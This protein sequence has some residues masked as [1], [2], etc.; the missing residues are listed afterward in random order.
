MDVD[1]KIAV[2]RRT[3]KD[4]K[5]VAVAFSGGV[6]SALLAVVAHD[7]LGDDMLAVSVS[8]PVVTPDDSQDVDRLAREHGFA[9]HKIELDELGLEAFRHNDAERCYVCKRHRFEQIACFARENGFEHVLEGSNR[10]DLSDYRPGMRALAEYPC[11]ASPFL[12]LGYDKAD[13]R[14]MAR[15]LGIDVWD[16]P[17]S[18]CLATRV[19]RDVEITP[20]VLERIRKGEAFLREIVGSGKQIRLRAHGQCADL[21]RIETDPE[22]SER[23]LKSAPA[24]AGAL[25]EIGFRH[26]ALDLRGYRMGNM[27]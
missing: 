3:I 15:E 7:A 13:V 5:R 10:D 21:A 2:L 6:D 16:K 25:E 11:V 27:N 4:L 20:A 18:S 23:I 17:A 19:E 22:A 9:L 24:V 26:I 8:S 1:G 14:A 12:E